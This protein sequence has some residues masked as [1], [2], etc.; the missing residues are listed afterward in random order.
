MLVL[1]LFHRCYTWVGL[2]GFSLLWKLAWSLLIK[3]NPQAGG[4]Q[5]SSRSEASEPVSKCVV[6]SAIKELFFTF[7]SEGQ[8][9]AIAVTH[10]VLRVSWQTDPTTPKMASCAWC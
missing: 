1:I 9:R 6:S 4:F 7:T 2:L 8:L 10:N 3:A 5:I